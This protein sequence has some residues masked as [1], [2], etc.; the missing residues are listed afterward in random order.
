MVRIAIAKLSSHDFSLGKYQELCHALQENYTVCTVSEYISGKPDEWSAILRHD[1]DRK[2]KNALRTAELEQGMGIHASY[3]FRYP[4]TFKPEIIRKIQS[5]GHEIGYHYE[6]MS[7]TKGNYPKAIALFQAELEAFRKV[8]PVDTICAHGQP[9]HPTDNRLL[10]K[11][12]DVHDYGLKGEAYLSVGTIDYFSDAGRCWNGR[13]NLRSFMGTERSP[14][15]PET[16][17][18]LIDLIRKKRSRVLYLTTHPERWSN[19]IGSYV[20]SYGTDYIYNIGKKII[21]SVRR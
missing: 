6:V 8:C 9:F 21:R 4:Y 14:E 15:Q 10:W 11:R 18:D 3:Y 16:T 5:L 13:N 7:K 19:S 12:Y 20:V 2:I 17:N 1:I